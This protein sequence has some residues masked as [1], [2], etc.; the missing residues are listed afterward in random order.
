MAKLVV[1]NLTKRFG[2]VTAVDCLSFT[3]ED[4]EFLVLIGPSGCGKS[5]TLNLIAGLEEA[6]AGQISIGDRLVTHLH[7]KDRDIAMVFQN[8]ALYPHMNVYA[9]MAFG[10]SMRGY[11]KAEIDRRIH[12]AAEILGIGDLLQRKPRALSGGQR[13][14]VAVGRAIVRKPAVF[15]FDEPLSNLDAKLR[16]QMRAELS[17]LHQRLNTTIVY[18]THDQIEAMTMATRIVLLKDGICQQ[19]GRPLEL[20]TRPVNTFTAG[21]IGTPP[22]NL[23]PARLQAENGK[24]MV[25]T[26]GF[27]L[28]IPARWRQAYDSL[29]GMEVIFGIRPE[30]LRGAREGDIGVDAT[31]VARLE[32]DLVEMLGSHLQLTL[33][34]GSER[35][36]ALADPALSVK[37]GDR[38][39]VVFNMDSMHLF[40]K[41]EPHRRID[42]APAA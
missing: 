19:I 42:A 28:P 20:Y 24:V 1:E 38:I 5:T 31:T 41:S 16:V 23:V 17:K 13:Q 4:R 40:E 3:A 33:V 27:R 26:H 35:L 37:A 25:A 36:I 30:H 14:R 12:E 18:V 9:N 2:A 8:Y 7:P 15:L 39:P 6:N 11:S 34:C 21:F 22:M 29:R 32:V 10:L